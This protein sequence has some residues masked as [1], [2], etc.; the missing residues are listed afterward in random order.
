[1]AKLT[2]DRTRV[3]CGVTINEKLIPDSA[4]ASKYVASYVPK[5]AKMKPCLKMDPIGITIHNTSDLKN[6]NDDAEQYTRATWPN[7]N[8]GGPVVHYFVDDCGAWQNLREDESGWHASD[9]S[10]NGNRRTIAIECIMDGSGS[11]E[12]VGARDNAARLIAAIMIRHGWNL[13]NLYTHNHWMGMAD[14]I[15]YG[16]RKN[17][18]LYL[19]PKYDDFKALIQKY[20]N[21]FKG[22]SVT[23][24]SAPVTPTTPAKPSSGKQ[25]NGIIEISDKVTIRKGATYGGLSTSRGKAVPAKCI[26]VE[27]TVIKLGSHKGTSEALIKEINSWVPLN[28]LTEV[29]GIGVGSKVKINSGSVYGGLSTSRGK[30]VPAKCVGPAYTV[31]KVEVHK[32]VEEA[33]LKEI[34]SWVALKYLTQA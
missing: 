30:A 31:D 15:T 34:V 16:A 6:V 10:G 25:G 27:Y 7:C 33:R 19:L 29:G 9:G 20:L 11:A 32:G 4:R 28:Y 18:P 22:I 5:G 21:Q 13:S 1:M 12:D 23:Q 24:P 3:E 17:C 26:G 2:P 8:M 14:K